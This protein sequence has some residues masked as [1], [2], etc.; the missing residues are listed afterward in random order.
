M[1]NNLGVAA[2]AGFYFL[3]RAFRVRGFV[4]YSHTTRK[5]DD[6]WQDESVQRMPQGIPFIYL[7]GRGLD[8]FL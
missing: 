7:K 2:A 5:E 4:C 3:Q 1:A 8:C 6:Q